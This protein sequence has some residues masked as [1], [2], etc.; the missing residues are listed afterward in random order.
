[1]KVDKNLDEADV[2]AL[3]SNKLAQVKYLETRRQK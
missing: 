2:E 3:S 1:M